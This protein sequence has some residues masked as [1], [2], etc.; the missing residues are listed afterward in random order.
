MCVSDKL[1]ESVRGW[2]EEEGGREAEARG[3][4]R[5]GVPVSVSVCVP[6]CV[7]DLICVLLV[8]FEFVFCSSYL[9]FAHHSSSL[10][11]MT[12]DLVFFFDP[13]SVCG[14]CR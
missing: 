12:S 5:I 1:G 9:S 6:V 2:E 4:W 7:P 8:L 13:I 14:V 10:S 3:V 11:K